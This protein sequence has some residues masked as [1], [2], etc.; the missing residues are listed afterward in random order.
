MSRGRRL[1]LSRLFVLLQRL[2]HR[3]QRPLGR[4][5]FA[6]TSFSREHERITAV[7]NHRPADKEPRSGL[8][9]DIRVRMP[10][11]MWTY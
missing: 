1:I 7:T 11:L 6:M 9:G 2:Y 10:I 4:F 3:S 5:G 8:R